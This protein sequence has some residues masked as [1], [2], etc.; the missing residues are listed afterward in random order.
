L[1]VDVEAWDDC[2]N[3]AQMLISTRLSNKYLMQ[4]INCATTIMM[5]VKFFIVHQQKTIENLHFLHK[6][7]FDYHMIKGDNITDHVAKIENMA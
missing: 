3:Y 1:Q 7:F 4:L 2:N 5:W 6:K